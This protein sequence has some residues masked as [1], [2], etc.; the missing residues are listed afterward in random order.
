M[1]LFAVHVAR[2]AGRPERHF[3]IEVSGEL[4]GGIGLLPGS[5]VHAQTAELFYWLGEAFWGRGIA[6]RA[7]KAVADYVIAHHRLLRLSAL[8]YSDNPASCRVLEKA[9]FSREGILRNNAVKN[10]RILDQ[11][12]Y[13]IATEK[14]ENR[15]AA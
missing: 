15:G 2:L 10:G 8:P 6:T 11:V 14:R 9:G 3:A 4:A 5:D 12:V 1:F 13:A 7:V